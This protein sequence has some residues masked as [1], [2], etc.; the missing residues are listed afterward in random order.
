[1]LLWTCGNALEGN[2]RLS[3][4]TTQFIYLAE[5]SLGAMPHIQNPRG[6]V[7]VGDYITIGQ[8]FVAGQKNDTFFRVHEFMRQNKPSDMHAIKR[9]KSVEWAADFIFLD[10]PFGGTH[11]GDDPSPAWDFVSEDHV[12]YGIALASSTLA[13]SGWLL[14]MAAMAGFGSSQ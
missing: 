12:R 6:I 14:V 8:D 5:H 2:K 13:D 11:G 1:M 7:V 4:R 9:G 10:L 3:K